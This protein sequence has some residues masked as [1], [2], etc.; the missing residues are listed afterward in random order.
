MLSPRILRLEEKRHVVLNIAQQYEGSQAPL[1][2]HWDSSP[3]CTGLR[4]TRMTTLRS[5]GAYPPIEH[6]CQYGYNINH[7]I[8]ISFISHP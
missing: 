3:C 6:I 1:P 5:P 2:I 7:Y 4:M 8:H